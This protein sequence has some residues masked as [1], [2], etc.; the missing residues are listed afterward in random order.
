[1]GYVGFDRTIRV[2]GS[3][4]GNDD[5]QKDNALGRNSKNREESIIIGQLVIGRI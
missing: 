3:F 1:M 4:F 5:Y 2:T